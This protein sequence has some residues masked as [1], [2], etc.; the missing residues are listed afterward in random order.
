LLTYLNYVF[1]LVFWGWILSVGYIRYILPFIESAFDTLEAMEKSGELFP[2]AIAFIAK[3]AMT[4][5]QMYIL[6]IWSAY[7]VLRT[8]IFLHEPGTN[9]WLYYITA[10][11]VCEGFLGAVAKKEKYR[12][13]LS[14]FHSAMAMGLF[15]IFAMNP[16]FLRSVYP[17]LPPMMNFSFPH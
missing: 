17:W 16:Y 11:L 6:G 2:R 5:S 8:M 10:F 1:F 4:G 15:V 12:G 9:G 7:C 3:L 14:V 13:L